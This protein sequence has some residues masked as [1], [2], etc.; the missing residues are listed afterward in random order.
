MV[1]ASQ[2]LLRISPKL[3]R[4]AFYCPAI[5]KPQQL[6]L[7][8]RMTSQPNKKHGQRA[9]LYKQKR[10]CQ[11]LLLSCSLHEQKNNCLSCSLHEQ[12]WNCYCCPAASISAKMKLLLLSYS[13]HEEKWN[14]Y[15]SPAASMSRNE[16]A[17]VI[18]WWTTSFV[19]QNRQKHPIF[20]FL[21]MYPK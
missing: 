2:S 8:K 5:D 15:C 19:Q 9:S 18:R 20:T 1:S 7:H 16:I 17:I 12:K 21:G 10:N 3:G 4:P 6:G 13:L 11:L 14:C